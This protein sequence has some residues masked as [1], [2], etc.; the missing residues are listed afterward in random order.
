MPAQSVIKYLVLALRL[1]VVCIYLTLN[2]AERQ[3]L[4]IIFWDPNVKNL[5]TN[6]W[7]NSLAMEQ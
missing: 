5:K 1:G 2:F 6:G 4:E 3:K 7:Q